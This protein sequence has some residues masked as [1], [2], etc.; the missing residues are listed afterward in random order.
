MPEVR[1]WPM[2]NRMVN[3]TKPQ[4]A[5]SASNLSCRAVLGNGILITS[6]IGS[7]IAPP[8]TVRTT[9]TRSGSM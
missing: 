1:L 9:P 5:D 8:I 7:A 4:K 3:A 2:L 6:T